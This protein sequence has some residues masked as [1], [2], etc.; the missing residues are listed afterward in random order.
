[1][2]WIDLWGL[3]DIVIWSAIDRNDS[4][5]NFFYNWFVHDS[6]PEIIKA[7]QENDL[8]VKVIS[9][10]DADKESLYK[11]LDNNESQRV[12]VVAHGN[13]DGTFQD[14]NKTNIDLSSKTSVSNTQILDVVACYADQGPQL[15][16]LLPGG[17]EVR[18]YN[19]L[20]D[21]IWWNQTNQVIDQKIP[22]SIRTGLNTSG[23]PTVKQ[24][25]TTHFLSNFF[26]GG[27]IITNEG[28]RYNDK[29]K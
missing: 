2:N 1:V 21:V 7:A 17:T 26:G 20:N 8:S 10:K 23:Q 5:N 16:G 14:V 12:I 24:E 3:E 6:Y 11:E 18:T 13:S 9:G 28:D 29:N 22:E 19:P 4:I 25:P 27:N 15:L